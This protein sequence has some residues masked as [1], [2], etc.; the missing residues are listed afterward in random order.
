[1]KN[2]TI[3]SSISKTLLKML[4]GASVGAV[5][6]AVFGALYFIRSENL[7]FSTSGQWFLAI[8]NFLFPALVI[9]MVLSIVLQDLCRRAI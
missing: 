4:A 5:I 7:D 2:K 8:Q 9:V 3:N 1:M 6:G